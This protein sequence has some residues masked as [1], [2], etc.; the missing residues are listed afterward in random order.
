MD[1]I[2][3]VT[4]VHGLALNHPIILH[5]IIKRVWIYFNAYG[6]THTHMAKYR[7]DDVVAGKITP[8]KAFEEIVENYCKE[9]KNVSKKKG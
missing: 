5:A 1:G 8:E 6:I 9:V 4:R 2:S 3:W 7:I